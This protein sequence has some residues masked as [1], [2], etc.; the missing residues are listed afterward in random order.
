MT[1]SSTKRVAIVQSNYVPWKGYFDLINLVD[2]FLLYDD[3]QYTRRDWRNRNRIKTLQG[4]IW[5]TIPVHVKGRYHQRIDETAIADPNWG[6]GHWHTITRNYAEAPFFDLYRDRLATLYTTD[7]LLLSHVNRA[8]IEEICD[9]LGI[10]TRISWSTD[11]DG[12]GAK[13]ERLVSLCVQSGA[14]VYLSGPAAR[15]YIDEEQFAAAGIA[16]EY[17]DYAGY[18]EY[19]QLHPPFDHQVSVLDLLFNVGPEAPRF[20]KSFGL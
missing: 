8:F 13:S 2:E 16:L 11:Y 20:M 7:E 3:R 17:M 1:G 5:L 10:H 14:G 4:P 19:K 18:P 12:V 15:E 9:I 6:R